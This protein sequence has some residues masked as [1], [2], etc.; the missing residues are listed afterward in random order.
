MGLNA[1]TECGLGLEWPALGQAS[2]RNHKYD[3]TPS[4]GLNREPQ[5]WRPGSNEGLLGAVF[6]PAGQ[7]RPLL[8]GRKQK[9]CEEADG[10]ADTGWVWPAL[11]GGLLC[12][13][14]TWP[15]SPPRLSRAR[16]SK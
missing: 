8:W 11:P 1:G 4:L 16:A 7:S 15:P 12:I 13:P 14:L 2:I 9:P 10:L 5:A 6:T 3:Q